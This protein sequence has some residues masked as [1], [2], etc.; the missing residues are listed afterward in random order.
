[1]SDPNFP[2]TFSTPITGA[3]EPSGFVLL[4]AGLGMIDVLR[5]LKRA[6]QPVGRL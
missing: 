4:S 2:L 1:M 3:P 6:S 5:Y